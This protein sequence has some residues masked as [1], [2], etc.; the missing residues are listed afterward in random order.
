[1]ANIKTMHPFTH[2]VLLDRIHGA[3]IGSALGDCVGL[4]T[5]FMTP[6]QAIEAYPSRKISLAEPFTPFHYDHHRGR[7]EPTAWTDDTDHTMLIVL[8]YLRSGGEK[9]KR[10]GRGGSGGEGK[11]D[12]ELDPMDL[13]KR[14]KLWIGQGLRCLDR[15]PF[16]L[17]EVGYPRPV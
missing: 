16:G 6:R 5:E 14:L 15:L 9:G 13:A 7:F 2:L 8:G 1:M 3:L 4:Y 11:A 10:L 12:G 17:G